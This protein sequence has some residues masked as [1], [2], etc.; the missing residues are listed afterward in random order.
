MSHLINKYFPES[1]E[2]PLDR[3]RETDIFDEIEDQRKD[4][5][6]QP[7]KEDL[8]DILTVSKV[9]KGKY[10]HVLGEGLIQRF[11]LLSQGT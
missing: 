1:G 5:N 8:E 4:K 11:N 10:R 7:T 2:G 3:A 9:S 6:Y